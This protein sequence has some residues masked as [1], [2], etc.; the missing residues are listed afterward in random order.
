MGGVCQGGD[1]EAVKWGAQGSPGEQGAFGGGADGRQLGP[2]SIV[3]AVAISIVGVVNCH[4]G[5]LEVNH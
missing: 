4:L 3:E 5:S 2:V 1:L